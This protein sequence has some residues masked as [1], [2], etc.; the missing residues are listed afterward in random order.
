MIL[1]L[2]TPLTEKYVYKV[3]EI[4]LAELPMEPQWTM[5]PEILMTCFNVLGESDDGDDPRI[6]D[7][8]ESKG[9]RDIIVG[10]IYPTC[11]LNLVNLAFLYHYPKFY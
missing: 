1:D 11:T 9:S 5:T 10:D 6:V 8:T 2:T 4:V 3:L 7:I